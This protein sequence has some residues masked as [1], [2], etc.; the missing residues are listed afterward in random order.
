MLT[1]LALANGQEL[2]DSYQ[3][4]S[5]TTLIASQD[6]D[7]LFIIFDNRVYSVRVKPNAKKELKLSKSFELK[8]ANKFTAA[9]NAYASGDQLIAFYDV[10]DFYA[11]S[12]S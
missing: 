3:R 1:L 12:S 4:K 9:F 7:T 5:N 6:S 2:C 11:I 10:N 8:S